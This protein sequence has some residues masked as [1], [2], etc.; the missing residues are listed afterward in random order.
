ML[1]KLKD[2]LNTYTDEELNEMTLWVNAY[3]EVK[4]IIIDEDYCLDL[5]T[6]SAEIKVNNKI[7]KEGK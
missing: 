2:I 6:D 3:D 4:S 7:E 5:I 1:K